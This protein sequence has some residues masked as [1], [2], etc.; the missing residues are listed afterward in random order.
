MKKIYV[1]IQ[2]ENYMKLL[3]VQLRLKRSTAARGTLAAAVDWCVKLAPM[4]VDPGSK[5]AVPEE[6]KEPATNSPATKVT[7]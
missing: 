3:E 7:P 2:E 5:P 4:P 6:I 1:E